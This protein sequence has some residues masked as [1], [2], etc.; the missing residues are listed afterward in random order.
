MINFLPYIF[1]LTNLLIGLYMF[2]LSFRLYKPKHKTDQQKERFE[3]TLNKFGTAI[4]ICS[5]ILILNGAYD[6]IKR[7]PERYRI[8]SVS[9]KKEWSNE[10]KESLIKNCII[11]TGQTG[12]NYPQITKEYCDCSIEKIMDSRTREEYEKILSKPQTE[13]LKEMLSIV[14]DCVDELKQRIDSVDRKTK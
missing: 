6:L 2:L 12:I 11:E 14:Q 3:K 10:D 13:K 7:D 9:N 8:G 4:K 1:G 5:I